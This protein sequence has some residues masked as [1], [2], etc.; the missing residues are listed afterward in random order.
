MSPTASWRLP[1]ETLTSKWKPVANSMAENIA[2]SAKI[3][4]LAHPAGVPVEAELGAV[5]GH[6]AGPLPPYEE[7][8]AS[9]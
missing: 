1:T 9:G 3:V 4:K 5:M 8:F 6:E 2:C 7:L